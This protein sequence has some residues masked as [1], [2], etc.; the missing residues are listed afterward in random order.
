MAQKARQVRINQKSAMADMQALEQ[1]SDD[2]LL[3]EQ[4]YRSAA[5][6]ILGARAAER[7]DADAARDYFRQAIAAARPQER[8]QIRRM[9]DASIALAERRPD[10]LREAV[11]KL[12]QE[13][14]SSRQLFLLRLTGL[15]SPPPGASIWLRIRG[16]ALLLLIV[17]GLLAIGFAIVKLVSIP[18]GGTS[19]GAALGIG[20]VLILVALGILALVGRI[21]QKRARAAASGG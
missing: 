21:R 8:M 20:A 1:R 6:S 7:Y 2:E 14:P 12:G 5:R 15:I 10:D 16:I 3:R 11:E 18:F 19:T 4:K 9:A 17:A 13:A